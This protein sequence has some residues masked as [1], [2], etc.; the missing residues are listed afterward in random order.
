MSKVF[1]TL[2]DIEDYIIDNEV[3]LLIYKKNV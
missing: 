2:D 3:F 1:K